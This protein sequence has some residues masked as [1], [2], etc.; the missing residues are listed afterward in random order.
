MSVAFLPYGQPGRHFCRL[1]SMSFD[2][3]EWPLMDRP[4]GHSL[5]DL[6]PQD[7]ILVIASSR[8]LT[9]RTDGL[10]CRISIALAEPPAIQRRLYHAVRMLSS[11]YQHVVTH[12]TGLLCQLPNAR[13]VAHGGSM[14]KTAEQPIVE[15]TKRVSLIASSKRDTRGHRLRHEIV[16]WAAEHSTDLDALGR[17]Y[18]PLED[19][20]DGHQPYFSSVVIENSREPGYFTEK[21]IDSF[22]CRSLPIYWGAP[23]IE[24]F[25]DARGMICCA[26][27]HEVRRAVQQFSAED[28]AARLTFLEQNRILAM[29]YLDFFGRAARSLQQAD[30][31]FSSSSDSTQYDAGV[32]AA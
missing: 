17:G 20:C 3:V 28:Y 23:D 26:S 31:V 12:N 9:M 22:L 16:E 27:A 11:R 14:L 19:K 32:R 29:Q 1:A 18:Q 25:F 30:G 4:E 15:K 6:G 13:F 10:R 5:A 7:Y 8:A 2:D 24:H 21:L